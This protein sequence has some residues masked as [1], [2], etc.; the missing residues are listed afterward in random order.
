MVGTNVFSPSPAAG[1]T[2]E[3]EVTCFHPQPAPQPNM[4]EGT[5]V[6]GRGRSFSFAAL[7]GSISQ[8]DNPKK[9]FR[10]EVVSKRRGP[11]ARRSGLPL[12][13]SMF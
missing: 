5:T 12:Q 2:R 3:P 4:F 1:S 8:I 13:V 10:E 7:E 9:K 6:R 11:L